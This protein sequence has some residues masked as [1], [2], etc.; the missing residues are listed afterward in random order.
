ME[1]RQYASRGDEVC[2]LLRDDRMKVAAD[3]MESD[4]VHVPTL[5]PAD[6]S[7]ALFEGRVWAVNPQ[8]KRQ[9]G[10]GRVIASSWALRKGAAEDGVILGPPR[11]AGRGGARATEPRPHLRR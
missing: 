10:T 8:V 6:D 3:V 9:S 2:T 1:E 5:S 11:D 4:L 7:T